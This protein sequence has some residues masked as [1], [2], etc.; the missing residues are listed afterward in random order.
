MSNINVLPVLP[1]P[2]PGPETK[3]A[4]AVATMVQLMSEKPVGKA[5]SKPSTPVSPVNHDDEETGDEEEC[6]ENE[7]GGETNDKSGSDDE[8][9]SE[10]SKEALA[11]KKL[12]ER[13]LGREGLAKANL[14]AINKMEM[15]NLL[16]TMAN[17]PRLQKIMASTLKVMKGASKI[18]AQYKQDGAIAD[19]YRALII[20]ILSSEG[21][22]GV[23]TTEL[24]NHDLLSK[25]VFDS[26]LPLVNAAAPKKKNEEKVDETKFRGAGLFEMQLKNVD[27]IQKCLEMCQGNSSANAQLIQILKQELKEAEITK[28][29][30]SKLRE[31]RSTKPRTTA[32][33]KKKLPKLKA[34]APKKKKSAAAKKAAAASS[35]S[36]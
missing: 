16:T 19:F 22:R 25:L 2:V 21:D 29:V 17:I 26:A 18:M 9:E 31:P 11:A 10:V 12:E 14:A 1:V 35:D 6:D 8:E 4:N 32:A 13:K 28:Q 7:D 3:E 23:L 5:S 34:A 33:A 20:A 36:E 15:D 24:K 30:I 27:S